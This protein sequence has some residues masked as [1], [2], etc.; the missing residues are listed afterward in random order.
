MRG[1]APIMNLLLARGRDRLETS[2]LA[3]EPSFFLILLLARGRDR[4]ETP[5]SHLNMVFEHRNLL[6]ARGRDRLE[7][8]VEQCVQDKGCLSYSL[9]DAI[10]W[11]LHCEKFFEDLKCFSYS[12][13]DAI[14]WKPYSLLKRCLEPSC[15]PTR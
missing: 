4:L 1:K 7:T 5:K 9:G 12:L 11:K 10:D 14:D 6:L 15:S 13:G 2:S 3:L 8:H